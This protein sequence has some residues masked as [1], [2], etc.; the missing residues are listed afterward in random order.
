MNMKGGDPDD[1]DLSPLK[2]QTV[3]HVEELVAS[4]D[5]LV[6][7]VKAIQALLHPDTEAFSKLALLRGEYATHR[8]LCFEVW[9]GVKAMQATGQ[10]ETPPPPK[11]DPAV[12]ESYHHES[13]HRRTHFPDSKCAA[14]NDHTTD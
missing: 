7:R 6:D 2:A 10:A 11:H 4:A 5:A 13:R 8:A 3:K 9:T 12:L 14:A 1:A